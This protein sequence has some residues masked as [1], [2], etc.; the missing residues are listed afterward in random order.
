MVNKPGNLDSRAFKENPNDQVPS[1]LLS[2]S[3]FEGKQL[4]WALHGRN[5]EELKA[6]GDSE[7]EVNWIY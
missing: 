1:I 7:K 3:G 5:I 4:K 2:Y 6:G